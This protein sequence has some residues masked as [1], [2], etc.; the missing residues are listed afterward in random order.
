MVTTPLGEM[1]YLAAQVSGFPRSRVMGMAGVL[2][3]SRLA[4]F[5]AE[6]LG[7]SPLAVEAMTLGSHGEQMVPLPRQGTGD[8]RPLTQL[9]SPQSLQRP[10]QRTHNARARIGRHPA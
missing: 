5:I 10:F 4:A 2:D 8:G 9:G 7:V 6:E 1:T 3:S